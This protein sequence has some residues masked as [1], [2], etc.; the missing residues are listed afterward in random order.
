MST[1][2]EPPKKPEKVDEKAWGECDSGYNRYGGQ[3]GG[4][5]DDDF[6]GEDEDEDEDDDDEDDD[7]D[8]D[9][10]DFDDWDGDGGGFSDNEDQWPE[11]RPI[12]DDD[13]CN[14]TLE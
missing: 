10:E 6:D 1:I 13:C 8:D 9:D 4:D 5:D 12:G 2:L 11:E 14:Q 7:D 3:D